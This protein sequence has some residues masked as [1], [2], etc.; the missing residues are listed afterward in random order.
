MIKKCVVCQNET[1]NT[2]EVSEMMLGTR[3]LFNYRVCQSCGSLTIDA[4]PKNLD[5]YYPSNYYSYKKPKNSSKLKGLLQKIKEQHVLNKKTFLGCFLNLIY[6][7][8]SN[9]KAIGLCLKNNKNPKI[10]DIG[11]G[12]GHLLKKLERHGLTKLYGIDPYLKKD[13]KIGNIKLTKANIVDCVK[14]NKKYDIVLLSHVL[15]HLENPSEEIENIK[16]LIKENGKII[17]RIPLSSSKA[18]EIFGKNWFQIDAPRHLFVPTFKGVLALAKRQH[19]KTNHFFFDSNYTQ[20]VVSKKYSKDIPLNK[21]SKPKI[22][23]KLYYNLLA[24]KLN[25]ANNGDQATFIF[26]K[27]SDV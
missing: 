17:I 13:M 8:N 6:Q 4:P 14:D 15:E 16:N 1:S 27:L 11:S 5:K 18:F 19:L 20:F 12:A 25:K 2:I 22:W 26:S 9:L 3:D 24:K 23:I 7:E 10:L 21:Q